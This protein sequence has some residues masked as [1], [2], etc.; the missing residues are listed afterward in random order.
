MVSALAPGSGP[1]QSSSAEPKNIIKPDS[2]SI[3]AS[4]ISAAAMSS[5]ADN[6]IQT[7]NF[8]QGARGLNWDIIN[9]SLNLNT[10]SFSFSFSRFCL[11][12]LEQEGVG[13]FI[14]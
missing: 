4:F 7:V 14:T 13:N 10:I 9:E 1:F 3:P 2:S 6:S 12:F 8:S 5:R 11:V